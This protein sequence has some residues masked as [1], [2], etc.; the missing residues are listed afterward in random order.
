MKKHVL[1][2]LLTVLLLLC[3]AGCAAPAGTQAAGET[4]AVLPKLPETGTASEPLPDSGPHAEV[5]TVFANG[6]EMDCAVFGSGERAFIILPGLSVH[7]VTGSAD[8]VA[9]AYRDFAENYTVY[10]FDRAKNLPEGTTVRDMAADTAAAMDALGIEKADIFGASQG[11]MMALWLA[12]D[13]PELVNKMVLGSSLARTN[14]TF[15]G[16][17]DQWLQYAEE[18][19]E[20]ALLEGFADSVYSAATLAAYRDAII[21]SGRGITDAEYEQFL[22][23]AAACRDFDCTAEL[24]RISCPVLVLGSEGDRIVT[25]EGSREIAEALG[26]E[27]YLYDESF[28]HGVYDEAPDYKQRILDFLK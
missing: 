27:L 26:C 15:N 2:V 4:G 16:V 23:Q 20:T 25:P 21:A 19:N 12:I 11:G 8:A 28:G 18:K 22:I 24:S 5:K 7:A 9:D 17:V 10:L 3:A 14:E 13:R 1:P 6:K